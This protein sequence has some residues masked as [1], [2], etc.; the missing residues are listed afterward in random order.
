[1]SPS[2]VREQRQRNVHHYIRADGPDGQVTLGAL[3][4]N[5]SVAAGSGGATIFPAA[6]LK[7]PAGNA[8]ASAA[9][10]AAR[11]VSRCSDRPHVSLGIEPNDHPRV[12]CPPSGLA[13]E[14]GERLAEVPGRQ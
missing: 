4:T 2:H 13:S 6:S 8:A 7:D 1:M 11:A 3:T 12:W 10:A 5:G 14:R 9:P